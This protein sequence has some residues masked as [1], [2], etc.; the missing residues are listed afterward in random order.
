MTGLGLE[1]L[2]GGGGNILA[3]PIYLLNILASFG[4][5]IV[6]LGLHVFEFIEHPKNEIT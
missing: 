3:H 1:C 6:N 4:P 2:W 5:F